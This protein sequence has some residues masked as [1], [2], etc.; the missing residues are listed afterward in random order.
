MGNTHKD[1]NVISIMIYV[2]RYAAGVNFSVS[3][4]PNPSQGHGNKENI[5]SLII[6]SSLNYCII[7]GDYHVA[8]GGAENTVQ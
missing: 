4:A 6:N 2:G 3:Y 8:Y 1:T 5:K 7:I